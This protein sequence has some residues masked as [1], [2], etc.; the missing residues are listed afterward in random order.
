MRV[1]VVGLGYFSQFHLSAWQTD[2][3]CELIG[4]CDIDQTLAKKAA[5]NIGTTAF[6]CID[7]LL[8]TKPDII[9]LVLPPASQANMIRLCLAPWRLILC[10]KPFC[11]S[12]AEA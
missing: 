10:Q 11:T 2:P 6:G 8:T 9:D 7:D 5:Q 12:L 4:V 3:N 1:G